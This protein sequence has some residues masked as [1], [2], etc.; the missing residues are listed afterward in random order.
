MNTP[1][2]G[3]AGE[4]EAVAG[5]AAYRDPVDRLTRRVMRVIGSSMAPRCRQSIEEYSS[6]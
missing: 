3:S 2:R 1:T 4:V 6:V 5:T